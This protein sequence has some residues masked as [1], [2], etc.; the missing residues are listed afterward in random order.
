M[1]K[2]ILL[3]KINLNHSER[4]DLLLSVKQIESVRQLKAENT[5]EIKMKS[6]ECF[7]VEESVKMIRNIIDIATLE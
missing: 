7:Y 5:T 2:F 4:E 1:P 6:S 3:T